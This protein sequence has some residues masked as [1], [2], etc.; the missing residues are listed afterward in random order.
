MKILIIRFSSIGD[1]VLTT[2]VIRCLKQQRPDAQLHYLTKGAYRPIIEC[3][4]Y[5][6]KCHY[7]DE[8]LEEIIA[9][10]KEEHFDCVIDLHKNIRTLKVKRALN[11]Q[12]YSFEKLN[13]Q[14]WLLVNLKW[15]LMPKESIVARYLATVA[16]LGVK[17][18]GKGL[19]YFMPE[20]SKLGNSDV[21]M[22]H[23][24]GYAGFVIGGSYQT[25]KLPV[26]QWA[27]LAEM[28]PYPIML[29]GGPEDRPEGNEIALQDNIKIY[30]ACGKFDLNESARLV[31]KA[32]VI[33]TNDTGL[34]H[35]AAAFQKP[36]ISLWGNTSPELGMFP[37]YG[38][39][40]LGDNAGANVV[41][42]EVKSLS[43][44]PCSKLGYAKC[45][46][47]HFKCMNNLNLEEIADAVKKFWK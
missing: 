27:R 20:Q 14:K 17:D 8:N 25:K 21:P 36:V 13:L 1:I 30:N 39:N 41:F 23:W 7:L 37:Y 43:C 2:P 35:I 46:K 15:N 31:E 24:A 44:H 29:L 47:G 28:I 10:L 26:T 22:S 11:V 6:S 18:D 38:R 19:D 16:P 34:M 4:P 40:T 45:P 9:K 12:H 42:A 33:V 5:I 32:K 3:N